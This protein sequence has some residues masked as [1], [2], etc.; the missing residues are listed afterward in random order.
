MFVLMFVDDKGNFIFDIKKTFEDIQ[1]YK[2]NNAH[3]DKNDNQTSDNQTN[4][5][6]IS[7]NQISDNQISENNQLNDVNQNLFSES[8]IHLMDSIKQNYHIKIFTCFNE[9]QNNYNYSTEWNQLIT[10]TLK[11]TETERKIEH[12]E[13]WLMHFSGE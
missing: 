12:I 9:K 1:N 6:Q 5:N 11:N 3:N 4:D 8:E 2:N 7:D 10:L 13:R